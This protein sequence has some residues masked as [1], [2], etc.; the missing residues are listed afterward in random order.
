MNAFSTKMEGYFRIS[1]KAFKINDFSGQNE[2]NSENFLK[3]H[4]K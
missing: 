2:S 4:L 1:E 3:E